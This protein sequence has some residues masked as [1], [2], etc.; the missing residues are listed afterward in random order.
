MNAEIGTV[1]EQLLFWEYL[2]QI[3]GIGLQRDVVYLG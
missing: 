2:L 3:F 1:A